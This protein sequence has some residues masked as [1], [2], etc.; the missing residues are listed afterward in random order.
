MTSNVGRAPITLLAL[1]TLLG[2]AHRDD[3][4]LVSFTQDAAAQKY[5]RWRIS[6][7]RYFVADKRCGSGPFEIRL[8]P[9]PG[10]NGDNYLLYVYAPHGVHAHATADFESGIYRDRQEIHH[11]GSDN[12]ACVVGPEQVAGGSIGVGA[13]T[14]VGEPR[15]PAGGAPGHAAAAGPAAAPAAP[16]LLREI[17]RPADAPEGAQLLVSAMQFQNSGF[18][19]TTS[20]RT[21]IYRF[22]S[23][24][25]ND[26][27]G[28]TFVVAHGIADMVGDHKKFAR[29][30]QAIFENEA[31]ERYRLSQKS[32]PPPRPAPAPAGPPPVKAASD[33]PPPA[34]QIESQPPRPSTHA[35]WVAG[36]WHW[37]AGAWAWVGGRWRVPPED[38]ARNLTVHAPAP[39]PPPKPEPPPRPPAREV[40]LVWTPG[41][42]QWDGRGYVWVGGSWQLA[43]QAGSTWVPDRWEL[44]GGFSVFIPGGWR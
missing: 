10:E 18:S 34:P 25:P 13:A 3:A 6:E 7:V 12:D 31:R 23:D 28:L 14:A 22:W 35:T 19:Y 27:S 9:T 42:W 32:P 44:R 39:P 15:R 11:G 2:C 37:A 20:I 26:W 41:Y 29:E 24:E 17:P 16:T 40:R 30:E 4:P 38:V 33:E 43:P 36:Y 8:K 1:A 21:V 5:L